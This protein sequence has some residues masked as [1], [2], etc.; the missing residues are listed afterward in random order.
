MNQKILVA[1]AVAFGIFAVGAAS[2]ALFL[3][4]FGTTIKESEEA[5]PA[6]DALSTEVTKE[7]DDGQKIRSVNFQKFLTARFKEVCADFSTD[8]EQ[9]PVARIEKIEYG[10]LTDDGVEEAI[11]TYTGC[12]SG[13]GGPDSEV[14]LLAYSSVP[15]GAYITNKTAAW[16]P[17]L[18][19]KVLK[20]FAGH[21]RYSINSDKKLIATFPIY[22]NGDPNCCPSGGTKTL[23]YAWNGSHFEIAAFTP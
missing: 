22:A 3:R 17:E 4:I 12:W 14:Y 20:G 7:E 10:D 15:I 23:T 21:L 9:I 13:T 2:G 1:V 19:E 6:P 8:D 16:G 18:Q 11:V 5:L